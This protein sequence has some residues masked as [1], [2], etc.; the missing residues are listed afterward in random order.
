MRHEGHI[1]AAGVEK[2][3]TFVEET[4]PGIN[5]QTDAAYRTKYHRYAASIVASIVSPQARSTTMK[6]VAR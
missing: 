5:E 3:V 4:D 6:L 1:R 2:D